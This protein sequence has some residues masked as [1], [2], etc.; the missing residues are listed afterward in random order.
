M[1]ILRRRASANCNPKAIMT[2]MVLGICIGLGSSVALAIG[3]H[4]LQAV[5]RPGAAA[6]ALQSELLFS[7]VGGLLFSLVAI[8]GASLALA[9]ADHRL[10]SSR[11]LQGGI[12]G[13]GAV[14]AGLGL[15]A[16]LGQT[17]TLSTGGVAGIL[18]LVAASSFGLMCIRSRAH[19]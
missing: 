9:I 17:L 19:T 7:T 15:F 16:F 10:R 8:A 11:F 2:T 14:L 13:I 1:G 4:V 3:F 18:A 12:A 6:P 5:A